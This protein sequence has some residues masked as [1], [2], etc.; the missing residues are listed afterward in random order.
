[1]DVEIIKKITS[2]ELLNLMRNNEKAVI[3]QIGSN[4]YE[5]L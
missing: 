4:A 1:M 5:D 2:S 3:D